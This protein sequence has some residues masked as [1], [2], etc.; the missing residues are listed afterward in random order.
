MEW[1]PQKTVDVAIAISIV[2]VLVCLAILLVA[3]VRRRRRKR[4]L[5]VADVPLR[6]EA[7]LASPLVAFGHRPRWFGI[8]VTTLLALV[9]GGIFVNALVGVFFAAA[10][11]LVLLRPRWRAVLSLLPAIALAGC[12]AY[13][14]AKQFHTNLPA[15]FEWPTFFWQVRTLG[16]IS[17]VFLAGD[18]LVEIVRTHRSRRDRRRDA[19]QPE[20]PAGSAEVD[21]LRH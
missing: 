16:W 9:G 4:A 3:G 18:A 11:L 7:D 13:I 8:T 17:I 21:P 14:A 1:V 19:A 5:V 12:G 10:V 15:T 6:V 20:E 2:G